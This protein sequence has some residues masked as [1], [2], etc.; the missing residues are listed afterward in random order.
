M[1]RQLRLTGEA[2]LSPMGA[3]GYVP[4]YR[5]GETPTDPL[6]AIELG[7]EETLT[8]PPFCPPGFPTD[9]I[10]YAP[11]Q[12]WSWFGKYLTYPTSTVGKLFFRVPG[13]VHLHAPPR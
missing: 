12:R 2:D 8:S 3:P 6:A 5:P 13:R 11:F 7:S 1:R 4:G 9:Y 10:N